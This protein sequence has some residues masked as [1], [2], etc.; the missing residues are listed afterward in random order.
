MS[1]SFFVLLVKL[2]FIYVG[3]RFGVYIGEQTVAVKCATLDFLICKYAIG[4]IYAIDEASL[5][6]IYNSNGV[7]IFRFSAAE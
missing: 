2:Y 3:D 7:G 6:C 5:V 4:K 1:S